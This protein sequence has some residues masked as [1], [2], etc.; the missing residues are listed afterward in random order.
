MPASDLVRPATE[1]SR[2]GDVGIDGTAG[3]QL[4]RL[5]APRLLPCSSLSPHPY[6]FVVRRAAPRGGV[7]TFPLFVR[8]RR[9]PW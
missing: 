5:P 8:E 1:G 2:S 9:L 3:A 7:A 6:C 4:R